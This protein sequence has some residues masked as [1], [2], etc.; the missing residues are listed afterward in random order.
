MAQWSEKKKE[1]P[2]IPVIVWKDKF[3]EWEF[4]DE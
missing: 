3:L 4:L 1:Q 2:E